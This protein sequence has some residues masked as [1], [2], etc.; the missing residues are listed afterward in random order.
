MNEPLNESK[1]STSRGKK[2]AKN[3]SLWKRNISKVQ[4]A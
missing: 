1:E 3:P 4:R 2:R